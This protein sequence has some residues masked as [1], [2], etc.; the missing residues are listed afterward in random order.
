M[1][2]VVAMG[3]A[4]GLLLGADSVQGE[5]TLQGTWKLIGGEVDGKAL[6]EQ[7][8]QD[9]KLIIDGDHYRVTLFGKGTVTGE[10]K[11]DPTAK[12][13]TID[14]T[15]ASSASNSPTCLGIYELEGD[16]F[17]VTFAPPG[18][19]RPTR[20]STTPDSGSWTHVWKRTAE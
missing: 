8:L 5:D 2:S 4:F 13:K 20:M 9:G 15:D 14:I 7:E 12:I 17:R 19:A 16:E 10:Q 1:K 6:S 3:L 11:L 18:K